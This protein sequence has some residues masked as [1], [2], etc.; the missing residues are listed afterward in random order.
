MTDDAR[1]MG[2]GEVLK[3]LPP[4]A[5]LRICKER[6]DLKATNSS[7]VNVTASKFSGT[8]VVSFLVPPPSTVSSRYKRYVRPALRVPTT[9]IFPACTPV[10][11]R[12]VLPYQE[13]SS[14]V[15]M[16]PDPAEAEV[17][18]W[19]MGKPAVLGIL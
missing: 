18:G 19:G 8:A 4:A 1:G 17:V 6:D 9:H 13:R 12:T 10:F 11:N 2:V 15:E 16:T 14:S 3:S 7:L 5:K